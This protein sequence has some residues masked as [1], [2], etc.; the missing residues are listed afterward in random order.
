M[1]LYVYVAREKAGFVQSG[2]KKLSTELKI[3]QLAWLKRA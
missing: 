1:Y 2:E 3:I